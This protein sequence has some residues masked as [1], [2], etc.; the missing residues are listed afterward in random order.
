MHRLPTGPDSNGVTLV[1]LST[2]LLCGVVGCAPPP[3][4]GGASASGDAAGSGGPALDPERLD[5]SAPEGAC[6]YPS[7]GPNGYGADVGQ[8]LRNSAPMPLTT[9]DG[10]SI[11]LADYFCP[12]DDN[13]GDFNRGILINIGAGWCGPCLEET[14]EF[15]ELYAEYHDQGIEIVQI[16]FQDWDAQTPSKSFCGDWS[17]GQ[18]AAEGGGAQDV[19]IN[20][21]FP[22]A[23][24]Q[25]YD[26]TSQYLSDPAA[27]TPVNFLLDANGT[28]RWKLEGQKP[29][30][31]LLRAQLDLVIADPY[32]EG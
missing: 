1:W 3:D 25:V 5:R 16:L 21:Q 12:R 2:V 14:L 9:C 27:A 26:W 18:W 7:A 13:Y 17:T 10:T 29:D 15:P 23:L 22:V 31:A 8:R 4:L 32:G 19:G 30:P 11:E 24:D 6:G 28:I 20:L